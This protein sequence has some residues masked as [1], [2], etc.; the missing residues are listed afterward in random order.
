MA[1]LVVSV[2]TWF[3]I[4]TFTSFGCSV[5]IGRYGKEVTTMERY[6][7]VTEDISEKVK[8]IGAKLQEDKTGDTLT[9]GELATEVTR[10]EAAYL[11]SIR[12]GRQISGDYLKQLTRP[13]RPRL[14]PS[15]RAGNTYLYT[16]ESLLY[17]RFTKPHKQQATTDEQEEERAA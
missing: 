8:R 1:K 4:L 16:V 12:A 6:K 9:R 13:A 3:H 10:Q 17:V 15:R 14:V 7:H 11:L 5:L 2:V